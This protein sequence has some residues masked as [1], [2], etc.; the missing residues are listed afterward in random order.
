M[1]DR[2]C[3]S[4]WTV[5]VV[6]VALVTVHLAA[7][8]DDLLPSWHGGV[9][10]RAIVDF[11]Q[12]VTTPGGKDFVPEP[13]R[14]ATFDNDGTLWAEQPMY[15]QLF[16]TLER[17]KV[18]APQHPEWQSTEPFKSV[19]AGDMKGVMPSGEAGSTPASTIAA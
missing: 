11:V 7:A 18:L 6:S 16:F 14:I 4:L 3:P 15:F 9:A 5:F 10:K 2:L 8:A 12:R 17:V 13:E 19:L 1:K